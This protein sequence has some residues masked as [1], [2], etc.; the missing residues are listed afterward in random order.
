MT[1]IPRWLQ[2]AVRNNVLSKSEAK[3]IC[4]LS[5]SASDQEIIPLPKHLYPAASRLSLWEMEAGQTRH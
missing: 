5:R 4:R 3:E 1:K 2:E